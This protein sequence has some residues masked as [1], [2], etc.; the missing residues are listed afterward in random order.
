MARGGWIALKNQVI[1]AWDWKGCLTRNDHDNAYQ[2][3]LFEPIINK[4]EE[5]SGKKYQDNE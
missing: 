5:I 1:Q 3:D 2:T 4:L